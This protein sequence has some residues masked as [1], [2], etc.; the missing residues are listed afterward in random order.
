MSTLLFVH[1]RVLDLIEVVQ[2]GGLAAP[3]LAVAPLVALATDPVPE[4]SAKAIKLL[5]QARRAEVK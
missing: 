5:K 4:T 1:R 3:W 2:R